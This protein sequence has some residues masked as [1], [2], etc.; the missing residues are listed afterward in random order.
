MNRR[1]L[2]A[3]TGALTAVA[4]AGCTSD[5]TQTY[6]ND[7]AHA[8]RETPPAPPTTDDEYQAYV[9][10]SLD[11]QN[12]QAHTQTKALVALLDDADLATPIADTTPDDPPVQPGGPS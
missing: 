9:I 2:L 8:A 12:R 11:Y 7:A 1:T 3:T 6:S 4:L 5:T 10:Q